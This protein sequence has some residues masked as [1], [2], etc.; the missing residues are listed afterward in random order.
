MCVLNYTPYDS[1]GPEFPLPQGR[2]RLA[3]VL[4]VDMG[5]LA[6]RLQAILITVP[7]T[8]TLRLCHRFRGSA[9]SR[10]P[11][12]L[13]EQIVDDIQQD[14]FADCRPG[15]YQ[16]SVCWQG[17]CLP[18][19]HYSV[20]NEDLEKLWR[21]IFIEKSYGPSYTN[22]VEGS[23]EEEKVSMV[24]GWIGCRPDIDDV[25]VKNLD[26]H[27]EATYRWLRRT[28]LCRKDRSAA[29][30]HHDG[31]VPLNHVSA[32]KLLQHDCTDEYRF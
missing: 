21:K 20:Y 32:S 16:D 13:L 11:Q 26:L 17:T 9:L 2:P 29:T 8:T 23:T 6:A 3:W 12:E 10:L 18:E 28:C 30:A 4:P 15:W 14:A 25:Q 31:F 19:D 22:R 24:Q 7:Q 5:E 27:Y 1:E